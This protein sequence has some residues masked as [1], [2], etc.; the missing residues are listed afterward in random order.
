MICVFLVSLE[1]FVHHFDLKVRVTHFL[2]EKLLEVDENEF[3]KW[4][5]VH[6]LRI[7]KRNHNGK[8]QKVLMKNWFEYGQVWDSMFDFNNR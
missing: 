5:Q 1:N 7:D 3:E 8:I 6:Q 2:E 4:C